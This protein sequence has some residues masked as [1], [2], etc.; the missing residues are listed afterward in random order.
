MENI[1]WHASRMK[2]QLLLTLFFRCLLNASLC[3]VYSME[4]FNVHTCSI[5]LAP[6]CVVCWSFHQVY[7]CYT[8]SWKNSLFSSILFF[9]CVQRGFWAKDFV[10]HDQ[11][12]L[13]LN[14]KVQ[15]LKF[16]DFVMREI[17][18]ETRENFQKKSMNQ[19]SFSYQ[20]AFNKENN[21]QFKLNQFPNLK[22]TIDYVDFK[23]FIYFPFN[24]DSLFPRRLCKWPQIFHVFDGLK[25]IYK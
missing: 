20:I 14:R 19:G 22:E 9:V 10:N 1:Y 3:S 24:F 12:Q 5:N 7:W 18:T 11:R 25:T 23:L 2:G 16:W 17:L 4:L 6:I 8:C 13:I 21:N 15:V